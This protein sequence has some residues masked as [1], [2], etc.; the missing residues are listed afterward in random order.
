MAAVNRCAPPDNK[1]TPQERDNCLPYLVAELRELTDVRVIVCLGAFAWY[2]ALSALAMLGHEARPRP[3]FGHQ[4]EAR[5]GQYT[6]IGSYHPSQQNTFT[7]KLTHQ[8]L[9]DVFVRARA[10]AGLTAPQ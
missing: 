4:A 3:K 8:M 1:P 7:G 10:A 2:G 6:L 9:L 5:V